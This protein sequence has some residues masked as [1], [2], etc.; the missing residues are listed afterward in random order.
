MDIKLRA[1]LSAYSKI[2]STSTNPD[3]P[4]IAD[5]DVTIVGKNDIGTYVLVPIA[6]RED[7][8]TMFD[9]NNVADTDDV[10][11]LFLRR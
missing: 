9:S 6:E 11:A 5:G 7:V 2:G 10:T 3:I 4:D 1:R 8:Q